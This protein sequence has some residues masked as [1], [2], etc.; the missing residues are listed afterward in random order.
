MLAL[1]RF[2]A[3]LAV[4]LI[5]GPSHSGNAPPFSSMA[6]T[7]FDVIRT[8]DASAFL[9]L[10]DEGRGQ[11]QMWDKRADA[12][13]THDAYLF[14]AYFADSAPITF[15]VNPEFESTD[16]ARAEVLRYTHGL[17]QLPAVLREGINQFGI[18]KGR[19]GF[20]AG[21][22][23]VF[24]YQDQATLRIE[25]NKLEESLMHEAVHA[26]LDRRWRL[27][28]EWLKAQVTDGKFLTRYGED[29]PQREDL[30]DT[31]VFA[32]GVLRHPGRIPPVDTDEILS[33]VPARLA[34][35]DKILAL[36]N[37]APPPI[38]PARCR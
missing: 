28:P 18:H 15:V 26:S 27:A 23:K 32:W 9:C 36:P 30:A 8:E 17:G 37:G 10:S 19:E 31:M 34:V 21:F 3:L 20:H 38:P 13:F 22:G 2:V 24:M 4:F 29:N 25:E 5:C 14:R 11:R 12:E 7:V 35:I 33:Q 16:A 1:T 6:D